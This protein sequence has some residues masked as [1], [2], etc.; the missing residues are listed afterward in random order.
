MPPKKEVMKKIGKKNQIGGQKGEEEFE[1]LLNEFSF[2]GVK[3]ANKKNPN[4]EA[5][6]F[7]AYRKTKTKIVK[8]YL[9]QLKTDVND[10][11][12]VHEPSEEQVEKL[13]EIAKKENAIPVIVHFLNNMTKIKAFN[14]EKYNTKPRKKM[15]TN[16]GW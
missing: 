14:A 9:I 7:V 15:F 8:K 11:G 2:Y 16:I 3:N 10:D 13:I 5:Y 4:N 6:D 12:K 1:K